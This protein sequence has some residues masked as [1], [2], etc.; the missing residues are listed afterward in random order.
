MALGRLYEY[1]KCSH[2]V[3]EQFA[4]MWFVLHN[5]ENI[6]WLFQPIL[7][8][9]VEASSCM[10]RPKCWYQTDRM[11]HGMVLG[12]HGKQRMLVEKRYQ[13]HRV[14]LPRFKLMYNWS[15]SLWMKDTGNPEL[16]W[17]RGT[18]CLRLE[19]PSG[20]LCNTH[21]FRNWAITLLGKPS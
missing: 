15:I 21:P 17:A 3:W 12:F 9:G 5:W 2:G 20:V 1:A 18:T 7:S 11:D 6:H 14:G 13:K 4:G 16:S 8:F 10:F 19:E